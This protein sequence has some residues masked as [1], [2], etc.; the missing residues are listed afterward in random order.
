MLKA[1]EVVVNVNLIPYYLAFYRGFSSFFTTMI[2][3]FSS[4]KF[5]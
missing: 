3:I 5:K 1:T 2:S 4:K